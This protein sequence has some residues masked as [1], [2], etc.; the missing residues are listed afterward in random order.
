MDADEW[1]KKKWCIYIYIFICVCVCVCAIYTQLNVTQKQK[2]NEILP[3]ATEWIYL[4]VI[5]LSEVSHT[6]KGK[7]QNISCICE[8][9]KKANK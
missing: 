8:T 3:F 9:E 4:E 7:D 2:K 5:M 1:I 6:E